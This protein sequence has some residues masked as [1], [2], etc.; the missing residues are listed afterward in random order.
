KS[1]HRHK[2]TQTDAKS[3]NVAS[4]TAKPCLKRPRSESTRWHYEMLISRGISLL[5]PYSVLYVAEAYH[6]WYHSALVDTAG[7]VLRQT[8]GC[9][10]ST[11]PYHDAAAA[12]GNSSN[13]SSS[14]NT[15]GNDN[16]YSD[17]LAGQFDIRSA[18]WLGLCYWHM[19]EVST[20]YSLLG[21]VPIECDY[22]VD[23]CDIEP[24]TVDAAGSHS[25]HQGLAPRESAKMCTKKALACSMWLLAMCCTRLEKWQEAEDNLATLAEILKQIY[26]PDDPGTVHGI[27]TRLLFRDTTRSLYGLPTL[28]DV[29]DLLG[30]ICLR[31]NR[32][33]QSE[34]HSFE[35]LRRNPLS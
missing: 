8:I 19:G 10:R 12:V 9:A 1:K 3:I 20:V 13:E 2:G 28:A 25:E 29:S 22:I 16:S 11:D 23:Q 5:Q 33:A 14:S 17:P 24:E 4:D 31:T 7:S 35:A 30:L 6:G 32:T 18:Y 26:P 15:D 34:Q 21:M 27:D